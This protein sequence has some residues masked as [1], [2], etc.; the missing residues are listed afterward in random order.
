MAGILA[1]GGY[2]PRLRLQ[3]ASAV[4]SL[5]WFNQGLAGHAKGERALCSWDEDSVTMAVEAARDC[6]A[7]IEDRSVEKILLAST[8]LPF[9]DRQNAGIVKEAL[10]LRN[11]TVTIDV[12]GS[13]RAGTSALLLA[14]ETAGAEPVL[15]IASEHPIAKPGSETEM[16]NGDAAAA[17][18]VGEGE[19]LADFLGSHSVTVDFVDHFR[20]SDRRHAFAWEGR[21]IRDEGYA[22]ILPE[23]IAAALAK[24]GLAAADIDHFILPSPI[25]NIGKTIA[26]AAGIDAAAVADSLGQSLGDAGCAQ[27]LVLLASVLETANPGEIILLTAFGQGCDVMA[28][29]VTDQILRA[30]AA[31]GIAGWLARGEPEEN[32][33]KHLYWGGNL[34]L[35][36]GIRS[37][38]DLKTPLSLLYRERK[39]FL[40]LV[41]GKCRVTGTVQFP[42]TRVSVA[43]NAR[44]VD[45]QDDYPLADRSARVVTFTSDN[46]AFAPAPP[47]CYGMVEFEGGGRLIADF[48]DVGSGGMQVGDPVR[49]MF[50]LKRED[51]RG[52]R[53]YFWKAAPDY[54]PA[55]D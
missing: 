12:T 34:E 33:V 32:Y 39:T 38:L 3:R 29:R 21:W 15:C 40:G 48:V 28:F 5:G 41:G 36:G 37:E 7:G 6:L 53:H 42:L 30:R 54:R 14:C 18:L 47:A 43:Q 13:Q 10:N 52:F 55:A 1:F 24:F 45:T 20:P 51:D 27:P 44:M 17:V 4:Q 16:T 25:A 49:M 11:E 46:L 22:K 35:D 9:A 31:L 2:V 50:R 19:T 23:A 26:K 8:T